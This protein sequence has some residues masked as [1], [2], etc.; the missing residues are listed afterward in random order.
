M[1]FW[2][3]SD[4]S[5]AQAS[6]EYEAPSGGGVIPDDTD[7]M[8][9]I[10]EIKWDEKDGNKFISARWRVAKPETLKNRV[11][12]QKMWVMGNNPQTKEPE[13]R[14]K[15]G[16]EWKEEASFFDVTLWGKMAEGLNTYLVK[17]KQIAVEGELEQ[18]RWEKDGQNHSKVTIT[19]SNIQ[20][21]GGGQAGQA[22][23]VPAGFPIGGQPRGEAVAAASAPAGFPSDIP[24]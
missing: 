14:K 10:D 21:L 17:G 6:T 23:N 9:F 12:F 16:D 24:F 15:Q 13:K 4:G 8:A 3:M 2:E 5:Q 18:E 22:A 19:A 20:L 7:V 11:V 1:S